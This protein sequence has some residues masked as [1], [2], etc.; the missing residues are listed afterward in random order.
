MQAFA[1][2]AAEDVHCLERG[3]WK[4]IRY[5]VFAN[6]RISELHHCC[7]ATV[8]LTPLGDTAW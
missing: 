1:T 2:L 6:A 8:T 3:P 5:R 7:Q 4:T